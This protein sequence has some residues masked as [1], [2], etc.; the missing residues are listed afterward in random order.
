MSTI[1]KFMD[2]ITALIDRIL[3]QNTISKETQ[4]ALLW[5]LVTLFV[6]VTTMF[7]VI[8]ALKWFLQ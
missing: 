6:V 3:S 2:S 5:V 4:K 7:S 1:I 8:A